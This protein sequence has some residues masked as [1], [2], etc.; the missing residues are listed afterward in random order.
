MATHQIK[1]KIQK[2]GEIFDLNKVLTVNTNKKSITKYYN[3]NQLPYSFHSHDFVHMTIRR[4]GYTKKQ[5]LLEQANIVNKY[6]ADKTKR[7]LELGTGRGGNSIY[8]AGKHPGVEFYGLDLPGGQ[9]NYAFKKANT[10][11][12]FYPTEGDFHNLAKFPEEY[13]DIVFVVEALCHSNEK[14]KV[15]SQVYRVLKKG[16]YFIIIDAFIG[17][18][19]LDDEELLAKGLV[20]KGMRV[21]NFENYKGFIKLLKIHNYHLIDEEDDSL[22]ILHTAKNFERDAKILLNLP[23]NISKLLLKILPTE[24]TYNALSGY[25]MPDFLEQGLAKYMVVIV[26]K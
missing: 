19:N 24:F 11:N 12:N 7:V 8:L 17:R 14:G 6:I 20:E 13:F 3:V 2:L 18:D 9:I 5:G 22:N 16:G 23:K 25:L 21:A 10:L 4:K 26:Q 1:Y 15:L